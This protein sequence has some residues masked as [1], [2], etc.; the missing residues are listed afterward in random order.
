MNYAIQPEKLKLYGVDCLSF[1]WSRP[2]LSD[3]KQQTFID[4]GS[5]LGLL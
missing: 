2:Y 1:K 5:L 4:R 3:E